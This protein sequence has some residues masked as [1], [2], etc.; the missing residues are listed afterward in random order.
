[1]TFTWGCIYFCRRVMGFVLTVTVPRYVKTKVPTDSRKLK[2]LLLYAHFRLSPAQKKK[3][4]LPLINVLGCEPFCVGSV[5]EQLGE[6]AFR[7]WSSFT[8]FSLFRQRE[9]H[10]RQFYR[11]HL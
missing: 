2:V 5:Q 6:V 8:A 3:L 1:M 7:L 4:L 10:R 11:G 9:L